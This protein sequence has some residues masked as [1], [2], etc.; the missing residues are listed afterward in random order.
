MEYYSWKH[1]LGEGNSSKI[2]TTLNNGDCYRF[3]I[4]AKNKYGFGPKSN[5]SNIVVPAG[6]PYKVNNVE[7]VGG[8]REIKLYWDAP[9]SNGRKIS[10]YMIIMTKARVLFPEGLIMKI[11]LQNSCCHQRYHM[12]SLKR[13]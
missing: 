8:D 1:Y 5:W 6:R 13:V 11:A 10:S 2:V 4:W 3:R 12:I 9:Y 7:A